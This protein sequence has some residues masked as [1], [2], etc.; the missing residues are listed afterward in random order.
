LPV[1][2]RFLVLFFSIPSGGQIMFGKNASGVNSVARASAKSC[3][4]E[5]VRFILCGFASLAAIAAVERWAKADNDPNAAKFNAQAILRVGLTQSA[6]EHEIY[7]NTQMTLLRSPH[8][9]KAA[10]SRPGIRELAAFKDRPD[11]I[12]WLSRNLQVTSP[13]NT[14]IIR[15][16]LA[17]ASQKECA[18]LVNAVVQAY[19]T[20][21]VDAERKNRDDRLSEL[22]RL[23]IEKTQEIKDALNDLKRMA[24]TL[25]TSESE[26]LTLKQ[27]NTLDELAVI[28]TE[29]LRSQF[30]LNQILSQLASQKAERETAENEKITDIECLLQGGKHDVILQ[31][32]AE[33]VVQADFAASATEKD[34]EKFEKIKQKYDARL[35]EIR[36]QIRHKK[37]AE[38]EKEIK[39]LEAAISIATKQQDITQEELK[40]LRKEVERFGVYS[41]DME[42]RRKAISSLQKSLDTITDELEKLQIESHTSPRIS[43]VQEAEVRE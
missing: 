9:L 24:E 40:Q 21:I 31:K 16:S 18:L 7:K 34:R 41:I 15:V 23:Q 8:V 13:A 25:G 32:L 29:Y 30:E 14:E 17:G 39:K 36:T 26:M 27:K 4:K 33:A 2:G 5:I 19:L 28:R 35:D 6:M 12:D 10:L 22:K 20:E 43:L 3:R 42:M 11:A 38:C 37:I 1:V